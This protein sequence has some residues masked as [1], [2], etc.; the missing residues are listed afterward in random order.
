MASALLQARMEAYG[1][2]IQDYNEWFFS[3]TL[4]EQKAVRSVVEPLLITLAQ[5]KEASIQE[6]VDAQAACLRDLHQKISE[7]TTIPAWWQAQQE[8]EE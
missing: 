4:D 7:L 2:A 5:Y 8:K 1:K 3:L 6:I